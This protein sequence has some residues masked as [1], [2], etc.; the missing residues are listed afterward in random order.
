MPPRVKI[1]EGIE[2]K[3]EA[4]VPLY[5]ELGVLDIR[6]VGMEFDIGVEPPSSL[7]CDLRISSRV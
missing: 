5:I 6:M 2:D 7:L 1:I 3:I 4:F